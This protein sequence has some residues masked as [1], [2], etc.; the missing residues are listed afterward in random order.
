MYT[1]VS[2][3][4]ELSGFDNDTNIG[5]AVVLGKISTAEGIV[6]SAVGQRYSLPIAF[7]RSVTITFAGTGTGAGNM[8]IT[9]NGTNYVVAITNGM[10]A[11]RVAELFRTAA[12]DSDDFIVQ[13]NGAVATL[14]SKTTSSDIST[15]DDEVNVTAA[16]L[17]VGVT[18]TVG[19]RLDRYPLI[20][21][22]ITAEIAASLLLMD[23]YGAEAENTPK[24]GEKRYTIAM[25]TLSQIQG[26]KEDEA[27]LN[28]YD[29][30]TGAEITSGSTD[31]PGF[32]P[33]DTS[34]ED[35]DYPTSARLTIHDK[36]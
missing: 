29:E 16:A 17:T 26:K 27:V 6:S 22:Q 33:T 20:I 35:D 30:V 11:T 10:T 19:S 7:H 13:L 8:T 34:A 1:T 3:V 15:A 25:A 24:D 36:W 14:I 18:P 28:I 21:D 23:N 9:I 32:Y 5:D 12:K 31:S 4:R 2:K